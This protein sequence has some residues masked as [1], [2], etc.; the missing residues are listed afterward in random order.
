MLQLGRITYMRRFFSFLFYGIPFGNLL[1][2]IVLMTPYDFFTP[3]GVGDGLLYLVQAPLSLSTRVTAFFVTMI[4]CGI[5][6]YGLRRLI[7]LFGNYE[8]GQFFN[9]DN[10]SQYK[11][12][13]YSLFGWVL[14]SLIFGALISVTLSIHNPVGHRMLAVSLTSTDIIALVAGSIVIILAR[15]MRQAHDEISRHGVHVM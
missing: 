15:V 1:F 9:M 2:W 3:I 11:K 6:M 14:G 5:L 4:P 13:S 8:K 7:I 10:V 12:L